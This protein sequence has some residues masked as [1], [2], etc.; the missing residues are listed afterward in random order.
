ME[1]RGKAEKMYEKG[2]KM[3]KI[4]KIILIILIIDFVIVVG[5]FGYK[6]ISKGSSS[7]TSSYEWV[8]MTESYTPKDHIEDFIMENAIR[9]NLFPVYIKN[10]GRDFKIL[11]KFVG[12]KLYKPSRTE[13]DF[14]FPDAK[15]WHLIELKYKEKKRDRDIK[16]TILYVQEQGEWKV[17]DAGGP[18]E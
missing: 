18:I 16:R 4:I 8:E 5:Y 13:M 7:G 2:G 3:N 11:K 17:G 15:D 14:V 12:K 10:Y 1:L 6:S 9:Q